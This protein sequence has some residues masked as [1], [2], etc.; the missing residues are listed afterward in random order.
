MEHVGDKEAVG[1]VDDREA[2][3]AAACNA[4]PARQVCGKGFRRG[5]ALVRRSSTP[6]TAGVRLPLPSCAGSP[7]GHIFC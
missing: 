4:T 2:A 6:T 3:T 7:A 5:T 1:A